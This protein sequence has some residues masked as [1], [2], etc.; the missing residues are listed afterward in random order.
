MPALYPIPAQLQNFTLAGS[1][2]SIGATSLTLSSFRTIDG[3]DLVIADFG[4]LGYM[5]LEPG[6]RD[7]EEQISFTGITQNTN[8]T[9]TLT[10]IKTVLFTTPF[11]ETS[12]I[13]KSHPG[14]VIT[15]VTNTSGFYNAIK[16]YIDTALS[17]GAVPA[18]TTV[19]GIGHVSVAPVDAANPIFVGD[20]DP[21]M[22]TQAQKNAMASTTTPS[23]TNKYITQSD[24]QKAAEIYAADAQ[25]NDTYAISP[26]PAIVAYATGMTFRVKINTANTGA[27]TLNVS[28]VGAVSIKKNYNV[29]LATGD[30]L[31]NQII[32][33]IYD[34]TNFQMIS[35]A[36]NPLT[37]TSSGTTTKNIADA[38]ATQTI[39]HGLPTTPRYVRVFANINSAT[40]SS[41]SECINTGSSSY[42]YSYMGNG[43][44]TANGMGTTFTLYDGG[45]GATNSG[46]ITIDATNISIAWT[47]S[48]SPTGTANIMWSAIA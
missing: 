23:A 40:A 6:S 46:V 34:G 19:N 22:P 12:G 26:S 11:T 21:R 29:D 3:V 24:L 45:S 38:N 13:L 25:A 41:W 9:A 47:K 35:P 16:T 20:N 4:G 43:T 17:A 44:S 10:G 5:T 8:G 27:A 2:V 37:Q 32:E 14:G 36:A 28:T 1:G 39:A 31:A 33:V 15:V 18:T 48:G 7:R 30:I 42:Q